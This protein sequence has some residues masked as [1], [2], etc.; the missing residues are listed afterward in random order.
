MDRSRMLRL[1]FF[2]LLADCA[3]V[4]AVLVSLNTSS[5][6]RASGGVPVMFASWIVFFILG[7][8]LIYLTLKEKPEGWLKKFLLLTGCSAVGF[9]VCVVLHNLVYGLFIVLFGEGFWGPGGDE[10]VFFIIALVVCPIAFLV[11]VIGSI[12][13]FIKTRRK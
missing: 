11:G 3:L 5:N 12:V 6:F 10:P 2:G 9:P 13:Q 1:T 8:A 7:A 4:I